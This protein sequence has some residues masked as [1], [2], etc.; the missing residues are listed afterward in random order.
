MV[1]I[2]EARVKL[3][4][5]VASAN[6]ARAT[7]EEHVARKRMNEALDAAKAIE[8]ANQLIAKAQKAVDELEFESK[9]AER[10]TAIDALKS[11][12]A[13]VLGSETFTNATALGVT[14]ISV[15]LDENGAY[16]IAIRTKG[17]KTP[18][19]ASTGGGSGGSKG[20]LV[21][22]V[23]GAEYTSRELLTSFGAAQMGQ[24]WLDAVWERQAKGGGF[25][26]PVKTL[27]KKL[28]AQ[29]MKKVEG[30]LVATE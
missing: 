25:D 6:E 1:T 16:A 3:D 18:R 15:S 29:L 11:A 10:D 7:F 21:F 23:E 4:E 17:V 19:A 28:N 5:A 2:D 12:L 26:Q 20:R 9:A 30:Q 13:G 8:A 27:A 22:V 14:G 24:E